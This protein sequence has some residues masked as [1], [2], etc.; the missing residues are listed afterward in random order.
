MSLINIHE[1][2]CVG[3][4]S[5][6]R[7]C[8]SPLANKAYMDSQGRLRISI[9]DSMCIKCGSCIAACNHKARYYIDDT[10]EFFNRL[11]RRENI[12]IIVAPAIMVAYP[13]SWYKIL[14]WLRNQGVKFIYDVSFGADICTWGHIRYV[15]QNPGKKLVSQPC[16]AIVNYMLRYRKDILS[17]LST[18]VS[19]MMCTAVYMRKYAGITGTIAAISPCV[20]KKD[21]FTRS[22]GMINLNVTVDNLVRTMKERHVVLPATGAIEDFNFDSPT[23]FVGAIYPMPGGLKEN[24]RL[25]VPDLSCIN[26]EGTGRV[27]HELDYYASVKDSYKPVVFDVLNCEFGCNSGPG[28]G[29]EYDVFKRTSVLHDIKTRTGAARKAGLNRKGED[30]QFLEFDKKLNLEDFTTTYTPVNG[31]FEAVSEEKIAEAY[32]VLRKVSEEDRNYD[33]HACGYTSCREMAKAIAR[34]INVPENCRRYIQENMRIEEER[35]F[36]LNSELEANT[37]ELIAIINDLAVSIDDV[38]KEVNLISR[39]GRE[40]YDKMNEMAS[41]MEQLNRM[42]EGI[43]NMMKTI[44]VNVENYGAMTASVKDIAGKINL[45]SLN[46]SIESARAGEA[47]RAFAVVAE[48]IRELSDGSKESVATAEDNEQSIRESID[49]VNETVSEFSEKFA[50]FIS[51]VDQAKDNSSAISQNGV[52]I[53]GSMDK[54]NQIADRL[55]NIARKAGH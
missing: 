30:T 3:C 42:N 5:C 21:E 26:S 37:K 8:P 4:N 23:G 31:D 2:K 10:E 52:N 41:F 55:E 49:K 1:E 47:G 38:N 29:K 16:A 39:N 35:V 7:V 12:S 48:N 33:C 15:Q 36:Q 17:S 45:L 44:D 18:I 11:D 20:A 6:I 50:I 27:Y 24:L 46:A 14:T 53:K 28:V 9:D 19:P 22:N 40:N 51:L 54:V 13:D 43:N 34:G 25:H 32:R